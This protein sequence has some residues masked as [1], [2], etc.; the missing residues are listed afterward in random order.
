MGNLP[1][2]FPID[3]Y[4]FFEEIYRVKYHPNRLYAKLSKEESKALIMSFFFLKL[5]LN[6]F[7]FVAKDKL[8]WKKN[9]MKKNNIKNSDMIEI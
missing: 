5:L 7:L 2:S 3:D 1:Y 9:I 4:H 6:E 8:D